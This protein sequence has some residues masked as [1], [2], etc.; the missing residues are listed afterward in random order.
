MKT[1][2]IVSILIAGQVY[3]ADGAGRKPEKGCHWERVSSD[4]S[5]ASVMVQQCDLGF[6]KITHT[7]KDGAVSERYSDAPGD[8]QPDKIIEFFKKETG[9][10]P[11]TALKKLFI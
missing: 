11:Q 8:S 7:F 5:K 9:D 1:W 4:S 2:V 10:T 3:A 6:R